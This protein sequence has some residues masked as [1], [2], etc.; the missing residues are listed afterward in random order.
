MALLVGTAGHVDHGKTSLIAALTGIDADRLP[1]EKARGM[2]I[3]LGF[4]FLDLPEVGRVSIVD[5]PGHERFFSNMLAGAL[6]VDVGLLCVAADE[7]VKRQTVE[8]FQVL[9]LLPVRALVVAATRSDLA[10]ADSRDLVRMEIEE[11]LRGSR[12]ENAPIRFVS[13]RTGEGLRELRTEL[14]RALQTPKSPPAGRWYL[15]IDRVFT[16]KGHGTVATGTLGGGPVQEGDEFE[17]VPGEHGTALRGRVRTVQSHDVAQSHV[18]PSARTALNLVGVRREE[19]HRGQVLCAPGAARATR[20]LEAEVRWLEQPRHG[21]RVRVHL[22]TD[23]VVG[24][25]L[26]SPNWVGAQFRLE[27]DVAAVRGQ[28]LIVRAYSPPQILGGGEVLQP[29]ASRKRSDAPKLADD[30]TIALLQLVE[31]EP[32]GASTEALCE[33]LGETPQSLGDLFES[34][35][36]ANRL[37]GFG[38]VWFTPETFEQASWSFLA[39]LER[40]HERDEAKAWQ[41]REL[42]VAEAKQG[43]SGK[44]LERILAHLEGLG[45]I[46]RSGAMIALADFRPRIEGRRRQAL[47]SLL[48]VLREARITLPSEGELASAL[49]MPVHGVRDLLQLGLDSG[50]LV[51]IADGLVYPAE[52]PAE[53]C[54]SA[55]ASFGEKPFTAGKFREKMG[56]SRKFAIPWLEYFDARNWT[57]RQGDVRRFV[58]GA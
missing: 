28:P 15:P 5:V 51:R 9:D 31:R 1:E 19:V 11:L 52:F 34:L 21:A 57:V 23:E 7:G 37:V 40:L 3:D 30:R 47:D 22:G 58:G 27:R 4:A 8:H 17:L 25:V 29:F 32:G 41:P 20:R 38:G 56:T 26:F 12:F 2:T 33:Q 13:S 42:A 6:G 50:E 45:S 44:P 43:W 36:K 46:R 49:G 35:R 39:A 55:R 54:A 10:D 24:R 14:G 53:L 18:E 48:R 16:V